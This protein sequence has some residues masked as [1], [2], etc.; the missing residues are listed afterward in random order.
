MNKIS[1]FF[2][3]QNNN[4]NNNKNKPASE[5]ELQ[6]WSVHICYAKLHHNYLC[7][8]KHRIDFWTSIRSYYLFSHLKG[9][10]SKEVP[11]L[12]QRLYMPM[13]LVPSKPLGPPLFC[14]SCGLSSRRVC[15]PSCS[16]C[17]NTE[18]KTPATVVTLQAWTPHSHC[19]AGHKLPPLLPHLC[20]EHT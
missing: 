10:C 1:N 8:E 20:W 9:V 14:W 3:K 16:C 18:P 5:F 15:L 12:P 17:R 4:I 19:D 7:R 6:A 11:V 2:F 13:M